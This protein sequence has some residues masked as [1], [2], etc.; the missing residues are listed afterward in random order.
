[1]KCLKIVYRWNDEDNKLMFR[2]YA[3]REREMCSTLL[4]ILNSGQAVPWL[5]LPANTIASEFPLHLTVS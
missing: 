5:H 1:M 3:L 4:Y 2:P